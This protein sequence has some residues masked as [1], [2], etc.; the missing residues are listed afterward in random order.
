MKRGALHTVPDSD[1]DARYW[2]TVARRE[3]RE[4]SSTSPAAPS[5]AT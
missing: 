2:E 3:A 5:S 1:F 4:P